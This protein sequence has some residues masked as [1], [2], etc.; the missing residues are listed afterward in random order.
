MLQR[1]EKNSYAGYFGRYIDQ[2]PEG[3]LIAIL[4]LQWEDLHD[5]LS[6]LNEVQSLHRYAPGK[7]SIKEVLGH[8]TDAERIFSYRMLRAA[9]KDPTSLP[10]FDEDEFV[11]SADF[12]SQ[13]LSGLL[14]QHGAVRKSNLLLLRGLKEADWHNMGVVNGEKTSVLSWACV[15][16][17]HEAHHRG[18]LEE[19]Y[20][21]HA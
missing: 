2:V 3:D 15:I 9:R 17:G 18:V 4:A 8:M 5:K 6:K 20:L 10:G 16:A 21:P 12:D 14:E 13:S 11:R 7:W 1:P 19:R